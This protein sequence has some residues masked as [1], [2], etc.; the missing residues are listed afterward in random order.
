MTTI[1]QLNNSIFGDEGQSSRLADEF[2]TRM[3]ESEQGLRV[4]RRDL[5]ADPLSHLTA[6]RFQAALTDPDER[7][8]SQAREAAP[9]DTVIEE[10]EEADILLI[11]SPVY[12]FNVTST[13]KAWFDHVARAGRTFRYTES[14]AEGLLRGKTAY[15]FVTSGGQYKGGELDFPTPYIRHMLGFVG[16]TDVHFVHAE[17]LAMGE[18]TGAAALREAH[19]RIGTLAA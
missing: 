6:E 10:L 15:V 17:G 1:L 18:E 5:G 9:A 7:T 12:N 16:I 3:R 4:I 19:E 2:I 11:A 13:L 8:P 14:G